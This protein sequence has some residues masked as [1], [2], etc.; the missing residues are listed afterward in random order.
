MGCFLHAIQ[1]TPLCYKCA[2]ENS[3]K[4]FFIV[5]A[6]APMI[7]IICRKP[8]TVGED[9]LATRKCILYLRHDNGSS[10]AWPEALKVKTVTIWD[11]PCGMGE[12]LT[13]PIRDEG[14]RVGVLVGL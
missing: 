5:L 10:G 4:V 7:Q 8:T 11:I 3:P 12:R 1:N 13:C 6:P 14:V 9:E 2:W